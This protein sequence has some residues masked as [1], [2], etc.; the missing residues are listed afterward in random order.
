MEPDILASSSEPTAGM[1][2]NPAGVSSISNHAPERLVDGGSAAAT[3]VATPSHG[4]N[5][6]AHANGHSHANGS[7]HA[8]AV[9]GS[10]A[11]GRARGLRG[12][13]GGALALGG[14]MAE[15]I[16]ALDA[17]STESFYPRYGKRRDRRARRGRG[18]RVLP[19]AHRA[20]RTA[21][22]A[23]VAWPRVLP[24]HADRASRPAVH[25][26]Q[27][28][29]DGA[30][31]RSRRGISSAISTSVTDPSSRSAATRASRASADSCASP[32]STRF[33]SS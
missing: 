3:T 27:A 11:N 14:P 21:H 5:G 23:R 29:L 33:R 28:A 16:A 22:Q 26:P 20:R 10:G 13:G 4:A 2:W 32:A 15:V 19:A 12:P 18:A 24:L 31:R 17:R 7:Q 25:V 6:H 9:N 1:S 30:G 8:S